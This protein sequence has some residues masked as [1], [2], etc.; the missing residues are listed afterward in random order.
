MWLTIL[1]LVTSRRKWGTG[2]APNVGILREWAEGNARARTRGRFAQE[3]G[4]DPTGT[5][6]R[7]RIYEASRY[8]S[9]L[10]DR[11][12][13]EWRRPLDLSYA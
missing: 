2:M 12:A 9:G 11:P 10:M 6:T 3:H 7:S 5:T 13:R 8:A 4:Q 1:T